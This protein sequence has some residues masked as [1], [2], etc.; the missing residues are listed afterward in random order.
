MIYV[1][2]IIEIAYFQNQQIGTS[3][4][5]EAPLS[6]LSVLWLLTAANIYFGIDTEFPTSVANDAARY[7][8]G[9]GG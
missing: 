1:W 3:V 2:R 8:L 6:M 4:A 7:L 9:V 5:K